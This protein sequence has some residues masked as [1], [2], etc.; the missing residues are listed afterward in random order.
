MDSTDTTPVAPN[1]QLQALPDRT[2]RVYVTANVFSKEVVFADVPVEIGMWDLLG[3]PSNSN[4]F[5]VEIDGEPVQADFLPKT[6]IEAGQLVDIKRVPGD[7]DTKRILLNIAL[8]ILSIWVPGLTALG[9]FG[10]AVLGATILTVGQLAINALIPFEQPDNTLGEPNQ[11]NNIGATRNRL[12]PFA[13]VPRIFGKVRQYP[14]YAA[15]PFTEVSGNDIWLN[16][17]FCIGE[18][19]KFDVSDVRVGTTSIIEMSDVALVKTTDPKYPDIFQENL[20]IELKQLSL[21]PN[22]EEAVRTTQPNT[23]RASIDIAF[24]RGLAVFDQD[25]DKRLWQ[26]D[27][28][29]EFRAEGSSDVWDSVTFTDWLAETNVNRGTFDDPVNRFDDEDGDVIIGWPRGGGGGGPGGGG[30]GPP[31]GGGPGGLPGGG[32][33]SQPIN[34][35]VFISLDDSANF[36]TFRSSIDA[37]R[38]SV[39]W[40]FPSSGE[41]EVRVKRRGSFDPSNGIRIVTSNILYTDNRITDAFHWTTLR[42][43]NDNSASAVDDGGDIWYMQLRIKATDQL[44]GALDTFNYIAEAYTR[45]YDGNNWLAPTKNRSPAWAFAEVLTGKSISDAVPDIDLI[46]A[47]FLLWD[48]WATEN[49]FT[50]DFE[51]IEEGSLFDVLK[52]IASAGRA[53]LSQ[54]EGK[55]TI[56]TDNEQTDPVQMF[57]RRNTRNFKGTKVFLDELHGV[58]V[59]WRSENEDYQ[60]TEREVYN[61]AAGF[62][63]NNATRFE[64]LELLGI[65]QDDQAFKMALRYMAEAIHRPEFYFLDTD[66]EHLIAQRGD[67]VLVQNERMLVGTAAARIESINALVVTLDTGGFIVETEKNYVLRF[68]TQVGQEVNPLG[69]DITVANVT[70]PVAGHDVSVFTV[71]AVPASAKKGDMV[72]FGQLSSDVVRCKVTEVFPKDNLGAGL[73]LTLEAAAIYDADSGDIPPYV[74]VISTIPDPAAVVPPVPQIIAIES[75]GFIGTQQAAGILILKVVISYNIDLIPG[76]YGGPIWVQVGYREFDQDTDQVAG[77]LKFTE[78]IPHDQSNITISNLA[79]KKVYQFFI[80]SRT[81]HGA[82]SL[83]SLGKEHLVTGEP[84]TA[85]QSVDLFI[86]SA[87][88]GAVILNLDVTNVI[89]KNL[90]HLEIKYSTVN[91]RDGD[92]SPDPVPTTFI[93][94]LPGDLSQF[95]TF[96]ITVPLPDNVVRFFWARLVNVYRQSSAFFPLSA[97]AGLPAASS[98]DQGAGI[99]GGIERFTYDDLDTTQLA[100]G[101]GRYAMLTARATNTSGSQNNF[102]NTDGILINQ[103]ATN[104]ALLQLFLSNLK[105][106]TRITFFVSP[107]RWFLFEID[108]LFDTVGTGAAL[109]Y[110][111]G[112]TL[113]SYIDPDPTVNISTAAGTNV[114]FELP[115]SVFEDVQIPIIDP[116]FDLSTA[117]GTGTRETAN[118]FWFEFTEDKAFGGIPVIVPGAITLEIGAGANGSNAVKMKKGTVTGGT[119]PLTSEGRL[120]HTHRFRTNIPSFDLKIRWRN[121]GAAAFTSMVFRMHGYAAPRGGLIIAQV[122]FAVP[123]FAVSGTTWK[124]LDLHLE[125]PGDPDAQYWEFE[126]GWFDSSPNTIEEV[127]I[128]SVFVIPATQT[129]GVSVEGTKVQPGPVPESDTVVDVGKVLQADGTW[130]ANAGGA[131]SF[132]GLTD[133]DLTGAA[134]NDL[135][136]LSAGV[137]IDTAGLLTWDGVNLSATNIGGILEADLLD[138]SATETIDG[139]YTFLNSI[140]QEGLSSEGIRVANVGNTERMRITYDDANNRGVFDGDGGAIGFR[141]IGGSGADFDLRTGTEL[142]IWNSTNVDRMRFR[143]NGTDFISD[144]ITTIDWN[145]TGITRLKIDGVVSLQ[146]RASAPSDNAGYGQFWS[147]NDAPNTPMFTTDTGVDIDLSAAAFGA[148]NDVT[149]VNTAGVATG[150]LLYKSASDWLDTAGLLTWNPNVLEISG[151]NPTLQIANVGKTERLKILYNDANNRAEFDGGGNSI[152]FRFIGG[153]GADFD[154]RTGTELRIYDAANADQILIRHDGANARLETPAGDGAIQ[155]YHEATLEFQTQNSNGT[156]NITGAEIKHFDGSMYDVGMARMPKVNFTANLTVTDTHWHKRLVH[157]G[158]GSLNVVLNTETSQP[159]DVVLWVL[160][161]N[162]T[163]VLTG[164][165]TKNLYDGGGAAPLTG[166]IT[167]AR[168]GWATVVKDAD[169]VAHVTGV[170]LTS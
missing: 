34:N 82:V 156:D 100:A 115:R 145:V 31:P 84:S 101:K 35:P 158:T 23:T 122:F 138:K 124:D 51:F 154:L 54:K 14:P 133:T 20:N 21:D 146:D 137:W 5:Y 112:V 90:A 37:F 70:L 162:G 130:V 165:M 97:T 120:I 126:C 110:K 155:F 119:P 109:A 89:Q 45:P 91:N 16:A 160:A 28:S 26:I 144:A 163:V 106:G 157:N 127:E 33:S 7:D 103:A 46:A 93:A 147:R 41:W 135:V 113:I 132:A 40:S 22:G 36:T 55:F 88:V 24:P 17:L 142:L 86:V 61:T 107:I 66:F 167:I 59:R 105:I 121:N 118:E 8:I 87:G 4:G 104:G 38:L 69:I 166:N 53:A 102:Q 62:G 151:A 63:I 141:F 60:W 114:I 108:E 49:N 13:I 32:S 150:D 74:P 161:K 99:P 152:G 27:F 131:V 15:N 169:G 143:H 64:V 44:A 116:D 58:K 79:D 11:L 128:D 140:T 83:F 149:D 76:G 170:G 25:G 94:P 98:V 9:P 68:R 72:V 92:G 2:Y 47:D 85:I 50:F 67:T 129:F 42:S 139:T 29:V 168:A 125:I 78:W 39:K 3:R 19:P 95:T 159:Q 48:T 1:K 153:S 134:N 30:G 136:F 80:R 81:I 43:F 117:L 18:G 71:D 52:Q 65:V 75:S 10:R 56:I 111:F 73:S 12:E 6:F 77:G 96:D 148:L 164:T 57:T 123:S